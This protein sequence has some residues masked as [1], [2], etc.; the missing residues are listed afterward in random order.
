MKKTITALLVLLLLIGLLP[1]FAG[2]DRQENQ[3]GIRNRFQSMENCQL[4]GLDRDQ[5]REMKEDC[6]LQGLDE[7][8]IE[9]IRELRKNQ[10]W[11][12]LRELKESLGWKPKGV[13]CHN[14]E[15]GQPRGEG[16]GRRMRKGHHHKGYNQ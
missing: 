2:G 16:Q 9:K 15:D 7:E 11:E 3:E 4:E 13:N 8:Q 6:Q 10:D 12:S 1:S 14:F 5:R